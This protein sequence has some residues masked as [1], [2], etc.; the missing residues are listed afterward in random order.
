MKKTWV[1]TSFLTSVISN[2]WNISFLFFFYWNKPT[3]TQ[4]Y[5]SLIEFLGK[6]DSNTAVVTKRTPLNFCWTT[7]CKLNKK[8][9]EQI[10]AGLCCFLFDK[11]YLD[12]QLFHWLRHQEAPYVGDYGALSAWHYDLITLM[13]APIDQYHINC[14]T[15]ARQGF[16]LKEREICLCKLHNNYTGVMIRNKPLFQHLFCTIVL[17]IFVF[18]AYSD[19]LI[20]GPTLTYE[21]LFN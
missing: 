1:L 11:T 8:K 10:C 21:Q 4:F 19:V 9:K 5:W 3:C 17:M 16:Y 13:D 2:E 7:H 6:A 15:Q 12:S 14:C 18:S 20:W